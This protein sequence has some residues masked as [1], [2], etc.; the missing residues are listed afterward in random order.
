MD[1]VSLLQIASAFLL[2]LGFIWLSGS[3][4]AR[5]WMRANGA[6][7][8]DFE[9]ALR[10]LDLMAAGLGVISGTAS[11]LAATAIM[12]DVGL[13]EA[14][15]MFWVML[16]GTDY[17]RAGCVANA[18]MAALFVLR[19]TGASSRAGDLALVLA[20]CVFALTRASM[21]H[22]GEDGYWSLALAAEAIHFVAIGVWTGAV[23]V[24]A[25]FALDAARVDA[26]VIGAQDRYLNRMSQA[27]MAAVMAILITG[28]YSAW[29]RV[30]TPEHL[31]HTAYGATLLAKVA[32]VLA[33]IALGGYN[34]FIGLPAASRSQRG[35]E[36]V[37]AALRIE[38]VFLL[39]AVLAASMLISQQPPTAL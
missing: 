23:L 3:W 19:W 21:G 4:C 20:L 16:T 35:L 25:W 11:L 15:P 7:R 14:C 32:L 22:A 1:A 37:R 31:L 26:R 28:V 13:R 36:Q 30:G 24:S 2:N 18:A 17:G 9:P 5:F 6:K 8:N 34:K 12:G 38:S 10:R 39:A 29:H 33:A 27:A